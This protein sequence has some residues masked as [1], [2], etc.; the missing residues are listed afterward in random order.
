[1][2]ANAAA[3]MTAYR[4]ALVGGVPVAKAYEEIA[5]LARAK[6]VERRGRG[7]VL[8]D[9]DI[10]ALLRRRVRITIRPSPSA[11]RQL[12]RRFRALPPPSWDGLGSIRY[13]L[14]RRREKDALLVKHGLRPSVTYEP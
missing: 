10:R 2:L 3:P 4:V 6:I 1:M 5:R 9:S 13:D 12:Y 14:R 11:T 8:R 7:W